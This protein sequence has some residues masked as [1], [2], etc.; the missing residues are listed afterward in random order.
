MTSFGVHR[1]LAN[2]VAEERQRQRKNSRKYYRNHSYES[3]T[4][5]C[6]MGPEG[7]AHERLSR[8]D[9]DHLGLEPIRR[10]ERIPELPHNDG[11]TE[12]DD[13]GYIPRDRAHRW[14]SMWVSKKKASPQ[15]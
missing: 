10:A 14:E 2:T 12:S 3:G 9:P 11:L 4:H 5:V 6:Y 15:H 1:I 13:S 8:E 7:I